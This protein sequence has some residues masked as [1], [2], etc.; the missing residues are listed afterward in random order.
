MLDGGRRGGAATASS[1]LEKKEAIH[2]QATIPSRPAKL[3]PLRLRPRLLLLL[4]LLEPLSPLLSG[5]WRPSTRLRAPLDGITVDFFLWKNLLCLF[6]YIFCSQNSFDKNCLWADIW[7]EL[8]RCCCIF[9]RILSSWCICQI[10]PRNQLL[11]LGL[12]LNLAFQ[13]SNGPALRG[14]WGLLIIWTSCTSWAS[15]LECSKARFSMKSIL[16]S[17]FLGIIWL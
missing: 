4:L 6:R 17:W 15:P 3:L 16:G 2:F 10:I 11:K 13:Q 1:S 7:Y 5:Y 8:G 9:L 12:M 14:P